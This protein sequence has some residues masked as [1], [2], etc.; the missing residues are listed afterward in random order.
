M[1]EATARS[2]VAEP[3]ERPVPRND[4]GRPSGQVPW[5]VPA[6]R[7]PPRPLPPLEAAALLLRLGTFRP[8]LAPSLPRPP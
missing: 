3:L 6:V 8:A 4:L 2:A 1:S 7:A 5:G